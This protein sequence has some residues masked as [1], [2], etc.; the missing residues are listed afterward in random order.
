MLDVTALC[1]AYGPRQ[2]LDDVSF[3]VRPGEIVGILGPNGAGK[4]T[5]MRLIAH[6]LM[7]DSGVIRRRDANGE[8]ERIGY[9]PEGAPL[10]PELTPREYLRFILGGN[11]MPANVSA[12]RIAHILDSLDLRARADE[13]IA[14]LS[15]GY[16][17]RTALAG[18]LAPDAP[19]LLLDEPFDGFDPHQRRAAMAMLRSVAKAAALLISSHSLPVAKGLCT[20]IIILHEGRMIADGAPGDLIK[21]TK[22]KSFEEAYFALIGEAAA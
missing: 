13:P 7:P 1:K 19:L 10:Y 14:T 2:A 21:Q 5:L 12:P 18:A 4:S 15:K 11:G 6:S 16:Q 9:L 3:G 22:E 20:R 17:R 8:V